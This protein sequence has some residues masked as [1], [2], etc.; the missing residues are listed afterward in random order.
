MGSPKASVAASTPRTHRQHRR[1]VDR[2]ASAVD[3][4]T[5]IACGVRLRS[6][7]R[8]ERRERGA[9][10]AR[11]TLRSP[12][13]GSALGPDIDPTPTARRSRWRRDRA[14]GPDD[15][16]VTLDPDPHARGATRGRPEC[17]RPWPRARDAR[18]GIDRA[19]SRRRLVSRARA[20]DRS[21]RGF[22]DRALCAVNRHFAEG[23]CGSK[24]RRRETRCAGRRRQVARGT[25]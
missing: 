4:G 25:D 3:T 18:A 12:A 1:V 22:P 5:V 23:H 21:R 24:A 13:S 11:A 7:A 20:A 17:S 2:E 9:E 8:S 6:R 15:A 19:R 14:A 10:P 16:H